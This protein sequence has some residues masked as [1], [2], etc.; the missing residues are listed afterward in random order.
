MLTYVETV[1][2]SKADTL[3]RRIKLLYEED[4]RRAFELI[5]RG[6]L[7]KLKVRRCVIAIDITEELYWGEHAGLNARQIKH[8]RGADEAFEW[9]VVSLVKPVPMILMA[10]PYRQGADLA[11]LTVNLLRYVKSLKLHV[12]V[13][14]FDR[15]FYIGH[16]ID[17]LEAEGMNYLIL[18]PENERMKFYAEQTMTIR[19]FRHEMEY[20]KDKSTWKP[21]TRIVVIKNVQ[22]GQSVFDLFFATSLAA[23]MGLLHIYP[24]RWQIETNFRVMDEAK[25]KS[26]SN[27]HIIRYFYFMVQ[28]LLH[29]AWN[30][31]KQLVGGVQFKRYL[32]GLI[33]Q[34][35]AEQGIT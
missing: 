11:T 23:S 31:T 8:E 29:L 25:I 28:L 18:V 21:S 5:V 34:F 10:L 22:K 20:K 9:L 32:L 27:E 7:K 6:A 4:L 17:F 13:A 24:R 2:G 12:D 35:S 15:S 33:Q 30:V 3:H 1:D 19:S 16:L 26:K 14:L